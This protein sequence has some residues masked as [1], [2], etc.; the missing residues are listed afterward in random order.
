MVIVGLQSS[1]GQ[2]NKFM[3]GFDPEEVSKSEA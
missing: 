3:Y 1:G 2:L